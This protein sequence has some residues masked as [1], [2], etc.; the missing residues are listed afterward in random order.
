M[1]RQARVRA[2]RV[3]SKT[4]NLGFEAAA[5]P[6]SVLYDETPGW[7]AGGRSRG[8]RGVARGLRRRRGDWRRR[9]RGCDAA[10]SDAPADAPATGPGPRAP[11][12]ERVVAEVALGVA[13]GGAGRGVSPI[14]SLRGCRGRWAAGCEG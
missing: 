1:L 7:G 10:T 2:V 12:E 8:G 13:A 14:A 6:S 4:E 9:P 3:A 11:A 5:A